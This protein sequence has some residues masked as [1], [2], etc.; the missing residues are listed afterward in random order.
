MQVFEHVIAKTDVPLDIHECG[1]WDGILGLSALGAL[2]CLSS[3]PRFQCSELTC[4]EQ[5][6]LQQKRLL[7]DFF[8]VCSRTL[9]ERSGCLQHFDLSTGGGVA[10]VYITLCVPT[11]KSHYVQWRLL[12]GKCVDGGPGRTSRGGSNTLPAFLHFLFTVPPLLSSPPPVP[13]RRRRFLISRTILS[14][15]VHVLCSMGLTPWTVCIGL[16]PKS[17]SRGVWMWGRGGWHWKIFVYLPVCWCAG[18]LL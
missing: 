2:P 6:R 11:H 1:W 15:S 18:Y 5:Q 8:L 9:V 7:L 10:S 12:P 3:S 13:A 16:Q 14:C 17:C 4:S